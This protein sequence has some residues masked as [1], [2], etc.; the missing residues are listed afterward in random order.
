MSTD[1]DV[2][3]R[4]AGNVIARIYH[5]NDGHFEGIGRKLSAFLL[6]KD[7]NAGTPAGHLIVDY[8]LKCNA[9]E[10]ELSFENPA[11]DNSPYTYDINTRLLPSLAGHTIDIKVI[12]KW[13]EHDV[14]S[15]GNFYK[16]CRQI[17]G[18]KKG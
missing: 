3:F 13:E 5:P 6:E 10:I 9:E 8:V 7:K 11:E 16:F 15:A 17:E 18:G 14:M 12:T 2:I 1:A 4:E